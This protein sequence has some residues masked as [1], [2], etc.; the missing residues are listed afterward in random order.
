MAY[1]QHVCSDKNFTRET[2][3]TK[4]R[5]SNNVHVYFVLIPI[6]L[7]IANLYVKVYMVGTYLVGNIIYKS[8]LS[9]KYVLLCAYVCSRFYYLATVY[10]KCSY[11]HS[12]S[13]E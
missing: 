1:D 11:V 5:S 10:C 8:D 4:Q 12:F 7:A 2:K 6:C 9:M 3:V 13:K